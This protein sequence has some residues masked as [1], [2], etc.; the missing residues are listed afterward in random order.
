ML[1]STTRETFCRSRQFATRNHP[2]VRKAVQEPTYTTL[3]WEVSLSSRLITIATWPNNKYPYPLMLKQTCKT[4]C[5]ANI[6]SAGFAKFIKQGRK[7][8][9]LQG[10]TLFP[11]PLEVVLKNNKRTNRE[12]EFVRQKP[13]FHV[14]YVVLL[15]RNECGQKLQLGYSAAAALLSADFTSSVVRNCALSHQKG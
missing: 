11:F 4:C 14:A 6:L 7:K 5:F 9:S 8:Y 10:E 2:F 1:Q 3:V 15:I 13:K 12:R